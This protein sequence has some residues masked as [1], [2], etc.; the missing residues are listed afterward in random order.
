[1]T[2][3]PKTKKR[4]SL[5]AICKAFTAHSIA[6]ARASLA[7]KIGARVMLSR[8]S[9]SAPLALPPSGLYLASRSHGLAQCVQLLDIA[10][11]VPTARPK[12][13]FLANFIR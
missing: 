9:N 5:A 12:D 10:E 7:E 11:K 3:S 2:T 13:G 1:M 8:F 4:L 6:D